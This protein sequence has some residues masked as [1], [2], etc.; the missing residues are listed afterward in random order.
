MRAGGR[1]R[2]SGA[3]TPGRLAVLDAAECVPTFGTDPDM[4]V[5]VIAGGRPALDSAVE[6]AED[7][8]AAGGADL[9]AAGLTPADAVVGI[10]ASG[11]TPYVLG[12]LRAAREA[13]ALAVAVTNAPGGEISR[14]ADL[15]VE[16]DTGRRG[17]GRFDAADRGHHAE[18]R[19]E[20]ALDRRP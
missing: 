7:D 8:E 19:A 10:S 6:G 12:A 15:A 18:D 9:L 3:G 2:Y 16:I 13:G 17:A 14:V 5:A 20:R 1:L 4:V 11:R